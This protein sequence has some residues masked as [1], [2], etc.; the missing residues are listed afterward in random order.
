MLLVLILITSSLTA[1][2]SSSNQTDVVDQTTG[3]AVPAEQPESTLRAQSPTATEAST[4]GTGPWG[5]A[6]DETRGYVWVAQPGC[7]PTPPCASA[8]PTKI[9]KF[10]LPAA[11]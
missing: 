10:C 3:R 5:I 1:C 8:F 4:R 9:P 7:D 2:S 6:L 11:G